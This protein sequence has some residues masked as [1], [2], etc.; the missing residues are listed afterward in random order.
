MIEIPEDFEPPKW[1]VKVSERAVAT[2]VFVLRRTIAEAD[3]A[4]SVRE[5]LRVHTAEILALLE[6]NDDERAAVR[7]LVGEV[8]EGETD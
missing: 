2:L 7:Q 1:S 5:L 8:L 6:L 3:E 4:T